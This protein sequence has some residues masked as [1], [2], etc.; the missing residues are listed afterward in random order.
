MA[1]VFLSPILNGTQFTDAVGRPLVG[2]S[3]EVYQ[4]GTYTPANT[5][6]DIDGTIV[7]ANPMLFDASGRLATQVMLA[8]AQTYR[9][10]VKDRNGVQTEFYDHIS[11]IND[12]STNTTSLQFTTFAATP[13][14]ID[15]TRFSVPGNETATFAVGTRV[16]YNVTTGTLFGTV[17]SVVFAGNTQVT[18]VPDAAG[19]D[20]GLS[21]VSTSI[22]TAINGGVDSGS[23]SHKAEIA[24]PEGTVGHVLNNIGESASNAGEL[25]DAVTEI[26]TTTGTATAF[27][28][29]KN[30]SLDSY[31]TQSVVYVKF[32]TASGSNPTLNLNNLGPK[33]LMQYN[34]NGQKVAAQV[35]TNQVVSL[36]FDGTDLIVLDRL[37]QVLPEQ[38]Q[39]A[40]SST[41]G[42]VVFAASQAWSV[43]A[44][45][46]SIKVTCVGGGGGGGGGFY[47]TGEGGDTI[48]AGGNGGNGGTA[49][50]VVQVTPGQSI[51]VTIGAGG[52]GGG[53]TS[54]FG[55]F[56][57]ATGGGVG[58]SGTQYANGVAG[59]HGN[60][61]AGDLRLNNSY[62]RPYGAGGTG[63][64]NNYTGATAGTA[65]VVI[66][67]W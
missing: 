14:F 41:H 59:S 9:F 29:T 54:S 21:Q 31:T 24:Y 63:S 65:G 67:E 27:V 57:Q 44:G 52:S 64:P 1:N 23:V 13:S 16:G 15:S 25:V 17:A 30:I 19:L 66:V 45:I 6:S 60:G 7:N 50:T 40:G 47:Q 22:I 34:P 62:F 51:Q 28:A 32:H 37:P 11:G 20:S 35:A 53:G 61:T 4:A 33:T 5:F 38:Q 18:I 12:V 39:Q 2:G 8:E 56:A 58:S 42:M 26:T 49:I 55:A 48:T 43:P 10:V 36:A 46:T 3:V